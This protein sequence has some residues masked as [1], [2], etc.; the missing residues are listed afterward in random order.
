MIGANLVR[1][2]AELFLPTV[3]FL[4]ELL[5][6]PALYAE[7]RNFLNKRGAKLTPQSS[8]RITMKLA[9]NLYLDDEDKSA[10]VEIVKKFIAAR[11]RT[12]TEEPSVVS[13]VQRGNK[14][15]VYS[16]STNSSDKLAHNVAMRLK[17]N[18]RKF[19]ETLGNTGMSMLMNTVRFLENT[20]FHRRGSFSACTTCSVVMRNGSNLTL[21][22]Q[23]A[24]YFQQ[25]TEQMEREYKSIV[26][27]KR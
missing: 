18:E 24:Q 14:Q 21:L 4:E 23:F 20:T 22:K 26:R 1:S 13:P 19:P 3:L 8:R 12:V 27:Q 9:T 6:I 25:A 11:R 7:L 10:D 5:S 15:R 2:V 16:S 17:E